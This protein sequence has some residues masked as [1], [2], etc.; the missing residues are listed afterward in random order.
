VW[1]TGAV[2]H[3]K[4][5][6]ARGEAGTREEAVREAELVRA[7]TNAPVLHVAS[8]PN[9]D[10]VSSGAIRVALSRRRRQA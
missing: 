3:W 10:N 5:G 2:W 4:V 7:T 9:L 1:Q 8:V 6:D